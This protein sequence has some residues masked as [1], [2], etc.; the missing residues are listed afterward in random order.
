MIPAKIKENKGP[1]LNPNFA[2]ESR[3]KIIKP[4]DNK[5]QGIINKLLLNHNK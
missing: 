3:I 1:D 4:V 2:N 5:K